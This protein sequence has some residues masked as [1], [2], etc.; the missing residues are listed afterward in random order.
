MVRVSMKKLILTAAV[1]V[2]AYFGVTSTVR[3]PETG[4]EVLASLFSER[5]SPDQVQGAGTV[6]K[7]L[8]DDNGGSRH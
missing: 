4:D 1:L 8:S 6:T 5:R 7:L 2:A 3:V